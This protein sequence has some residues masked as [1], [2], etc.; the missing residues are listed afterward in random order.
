MQC[1][2]GGEASTKTAQREANKA[3]RSFYQCP[4]CK[5]VSDGVLF[6]N[7]I[8]VA[9]DQGGQTLA[10]DAFN[11]LSAESARALLMAAQ[12]KSDSCAQTEFAF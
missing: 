5:R 11:S 7:D 2:C 10:R 6:I 9:R 3:V 12:P 8:E 4:R 1:S